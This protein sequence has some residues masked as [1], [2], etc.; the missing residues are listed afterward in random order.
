MLVSA[1]TLSLPLDE[2]DFVLETDSSGAELIQW[3]GG[4]LKIIEYFSRGEERFCTTRLEVTAV[5]NALQ[6]F[7]KFLIGRKFTLRVDY[8]P[9]LYYAKTKEPMGQVA[10]HIAFLA[11][12]DFVLEYKS[13]PTL[14]IPDALS[15]LRLCE[16]GPKQCHKQYTGRHT[17]NS[18]NVNQITTRAQ[19]KL[20]KPEITKQS[21]QT[22]TD[23]D[24]CHHNHYYE[25]QSVPVVSPK[26]SHAIDNN[27]LIAKT[28]GK[29]IAL[30]VEG[31]TSA[32]LRE[33]QQ[34]DADIAPA[35]VWL[36]GAE[37]RPE[38]SFVA[39]ASPALRALY[40]QYESLVL[41]E[42]ILY[43]IFHN[44]DA[45]CVFSSIC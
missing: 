33:Q 6:H 25:C 30:Q 37:G 36:K 44:L 11:D 16:R 14:K 40:Q 4:Q 34:A 28:A 8:K 31:C 35:L 22:S 10:R 15:R 26:P 13:G 39:A 1:S 27:S 18:R 43:H 2:G 41:R 42:G 19:A 45:L 9:L 21:M 29:A 7:C 32:Y 23:S 24:S 3:Q 12:F 17:I 5:V 20:L 38:W